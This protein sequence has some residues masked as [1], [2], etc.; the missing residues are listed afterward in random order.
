M[1]ILQLIVYKEWLSSERFLFAK[2]P[3]FHPFDLRLV[4]DLADYHHSTLRNNAWS[5][6][7]ATIKL[8][9]KRIYIAI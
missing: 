9:H 1:E 2:H 3:V 4:Q 6:H 8:Y 5:L 7:L